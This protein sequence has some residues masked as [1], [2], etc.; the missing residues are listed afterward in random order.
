MTVGMIW[1][2]LLSGIEDEIP[3]GISINRLYLV[4][5]LEMVVAGAD[6]T[7]G[8]VLRL[9]SYPADDS[10][11]G[12]WAPP[13][14]QYR[15]DEKS[16][17]DDNP[18]RL[19]RKCR[20]YQKKNAESIRRDIV[21]FAESFG[22][23]DAVVELV[24]EAPILEVKPS[25]NEPNKTNAFYQLRFTLR[26]VEWG[27]EVN[28][29]D[30]EGRYGFIHLSIGTEG[31][32]IPAFSVEPER[33]K[34]GELLHL[35]KPLISSL[36]RILENPVELANLRGTILHEGD[37]ILPTA[38][39]EEG[40]VVVADIA[41][42]GRVLTVNYI[43]YIGDR[44]NEQRKYQARVLSALEKALVDTGTTQVQTVGDGF[45]AAYPVPRN[46]DRLA[47]KIT[48]TVANWTRAVRIVHRD[49]NRLLREAG[50]PQCLGSRIAINFGNYEWGRING[51]GSFSPA[52]NGRAVVDAARLEQGLNGYMAT[53]VEA[54]RISAD[55]HLMAVAPSLSKDV[56]NVE[57]KLNEL[58]WT[59]LDPTELR[60]KEKVFEMV[61][62][63]A[64]EEC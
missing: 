23:R 60:A 9:H 19:M 57:D 63:F 22:L 61:D 13:N 29:I 16:E 40:L 42:Y 4:A 59:R 58:G 62:V 44:E 43:G 49:V 1:P 48:S 30:R 24:S 54:E 51:F 53:E 2:I 55:A 64:W 38:R 37:S 21:L 26:H 36:Q 3:Y 34:Y 39:S 17:V 33:T 5:S 31:Q 7:A 8:M 32:R 27:S 46:G 11:E 18:G 20:N 10:R 50:N 14:L 25:I 47:K 35:G 15:L 56:R 41:G 52:F 28:L 6:G 12:Y 45:V